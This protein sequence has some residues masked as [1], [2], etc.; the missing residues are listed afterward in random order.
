V[1]RAAREL[2]LLAEWLRG[3]NGFPGNKMVL[4]LL[5]VRLI[6]GQSNID[7]DAVFEECGAAL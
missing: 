5:A 4:R 3:R 2:V 7:V 6:A 1:S